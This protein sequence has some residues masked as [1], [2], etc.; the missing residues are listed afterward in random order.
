M[1]RPDGRALAVSH[2]PLP[3]GGWVATYEDVT[4]RR[5]TEERVAFMAHHDVLTGLPNRA[6]YR[7]RIEE[8]LR[9]DQSG[10]RRRRC[11]CSTSTIS[12]RSTTRSAT[13]PATR[14]CGRWRSGCGGDARRRPG[15]AAGRRRVRRH[16]VARRR[17]VDAGR[18]ADRIVAAISEPYEIDGERVLVGASVG[19]AIEPHEGATADLLL[20]YADMA[21]YRPR[22]TGAAT[23]CFYEPRMDE[24]ARSRRALSADLRDAIR[25]GQLEVHYQPLVGLRDRPGGGFEALL[26][27]RHPERGLIPPGAVHPDRR[28]DRPDL[29]DRRLGAAA[30]VPEATGWPRRVGVSVNLSPRQFQDGNVAGVVEGA[31]DAKRFG[32]G[33]A[34]TGDHRIAAVA[35]R[36][37]C[38]RC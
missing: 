36:D 30:G 18:L 22:R 4:E 33:A 9:R 6:L 2:Q 23:Y 17:A 8:L 7:E 11:C 34:G 31:L 15:G 38:W 16:P 26:R 12:R 3:N 37:A 13:A 29:G 35:G 21:L 1:R 10:R 5:R 32:A 28:G 25:L 27:W 19:I 24:K 20:K 14:C